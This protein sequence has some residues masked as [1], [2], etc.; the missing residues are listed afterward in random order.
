MAMS[1]ISRSHFRSH[2]RPVIAASLC[3]AALAGCAGYYLIG[4]APHEGVPPGA[5]SYR[6][7]TCTRTSDELPVA[8]PAGLSWHVIT[9]DR[10]L[11]LV[12]IDNATRG[13]NEVRNRWSDAEADHFFA[14]EDKKVGYQWII[15]AERGQKGRRLVYAPGT[16]T[17]TTVDGKLQP[18]GEPETV[19]ELHPAL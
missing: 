19:C 4:A 15:P 17:V 8:G 12:E 13:G 11:T 14:Y 9:G 7:G 6:L 3:A 1:M 16:Y 10:G 2:V 5:W 18:Q